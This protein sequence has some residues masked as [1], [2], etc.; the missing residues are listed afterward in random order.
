MRLQLAAVPSQDVGAIA[1][2]ERVS[3]LWKEHELVVDEEPAE[4]EASKK[5]EELLEECRRR[6]ATE[7]EYS[8]AE[9][10]GFST[11]KVRHFADRHQEHFG[12]IH[13]RLTTMWTMFSFFFA[14]TAKV[15]GSCS[16][17]AMTS[18]L[19]SPLCHD[20]SGGV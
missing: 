4:P 12:G 15:Q 16:S 14:F 1:V 9:L 17:C 5:E 7:G 20:T 8:T 13:M 19:E 3:G 10:E 2:P 6:A 11:R 18:T